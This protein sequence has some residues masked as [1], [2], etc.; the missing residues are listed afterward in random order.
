[1]NIKTNRDESFL[2]DNDILNKIII[3]SC[4]SNID[5][6]KTLEYVYMDGTFNCCTKHNTQ[7]M[8]SKMVYIFY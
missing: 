7:F 5:F 4:Q 2:F 6:L 1:M 3:F 8:D